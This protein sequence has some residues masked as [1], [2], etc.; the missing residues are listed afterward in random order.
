QG[1]LRPV[2]HQHAR[3]GAADAGRG[4]GDD[5]MPAGEIGHFSPSSPA[6]FSLRISG[7]TSSRKPAS[8][9]SFIHLSGV[10]KGKS[11]PNSIFRFSWVFAYWITCFGKYLGDQPERS[12]N[13][14]SLCSA[15][16]RLSSVH[17]QLGWA[18]MIFM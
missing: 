1:H 10:I 14:F 5:D 18:R 3:G 7:I 9:A 15:M 8:S 16:E 17:G 2:P 13:T 12:M 4:A 6:A 11:E